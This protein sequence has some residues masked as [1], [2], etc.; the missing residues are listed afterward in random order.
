MPSRADMLR[1]FI[2][3]RPQDPFPKYALALEHKNAGEL[4]EAWQVF[5]T[6]LGAHPDYTATYLHAGQTLLTLGR[7][8][9]ARG[10]FTRGIEVCTRAGDTH[11]R[12]EL[13]GALAA[14]GASAPSDL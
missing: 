1:N 9:E 6:L 4:T 11:A 12:S 8:P 13:E 5:E 3:Q 7:V 2:V 14:V 10:L